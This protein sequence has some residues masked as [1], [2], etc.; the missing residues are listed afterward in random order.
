MFSWVT[1]TELRLRYII[2]PSS[3]G[4]YS[5]ATPTEFTK[6]TEEVYE[7]RRRSLRRTPKE[8]TK[9]AEGVFYNLCSDVISSSNS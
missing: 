2:T 8:F 6:N 4:G 3:T 5:Q 7:E 1:P 9:N